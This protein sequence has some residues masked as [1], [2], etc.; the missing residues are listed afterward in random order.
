MVNQPTITTI[1][2]PA[3]EGRKHAREKIYER[4]SMREGTQ[5]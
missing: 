5:K 2:E 4:E 3:R 1:E